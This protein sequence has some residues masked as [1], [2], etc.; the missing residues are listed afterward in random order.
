MVLTTDLS[1]KG[2]RQLKK[3]LRQYQRQTLPE[4]MR[5]VVERLADDGIYL[6]KA[7]SRQSEFY[8]YVGFYKENVAQKYGYKVSAVL[9]GANRIPCLKEWFRDDQLIQREVN[10]L[11]MIE[12]GSGVGAVLGHRGTFPRDDGNPSKGKQNA[13][14]YATSMIKDEKGRDVYDWQMSTGEVALQ[15]MREA[16]DMIELECDTILRQVF[17]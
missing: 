4:T 9:V 7:V 1:V 10:A 12:Y 14:W 11:M 13:W 3:D 16:R 5:Q 8:P 17:G 6:A 15:P 2:L